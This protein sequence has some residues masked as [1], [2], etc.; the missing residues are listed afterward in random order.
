MKSMSFGL[1]AAVVSAGAVFLS[2]CG[3]EK[4]QRCNLMW[5][6]CELSVALV[7]TAWEPGE[8]VFEATGNGETHRCAVSLPAST[9]ES[10]DCSGTRLGPSRAWE[11]EPY[12]SSIALDRS[13]GA[14]AVRILYQGQEIA[15]ETF[16]PRYKESEPNGEG[17]GICKNA[18]VTMEF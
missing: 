5:P 12:P 18:E 6:R 16:Q 8:Y 2:G 10:W 15:S 14:V 17:C 11:V 3:D 1:L 4:E 9:R 7:P 13:S